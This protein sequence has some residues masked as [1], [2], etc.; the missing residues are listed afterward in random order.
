MILCTHD[1]NLI[2]TDHY[3]IGKTT[4]FD[5][6]THTI[7]F[8]PIG[9]DQLEFHHVDWG[10]PHSNRPAEID[11]TAYRRYVLRIMPSG[12]LGLD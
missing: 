1:T 4:D 7:Q 2:L 11:T 3:Y 12:K 9:P 5:G 10:Y 6:R 8:N